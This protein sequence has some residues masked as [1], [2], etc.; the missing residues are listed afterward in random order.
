MTVSKAERLQRSRLGPPVRGAVSRLR[1]PMWKLRGSPA[2]APP[3]RK[4]RVVASYARRVGADTFVETGTYRGDTLAL[5]AP[6]VKQAISIELD[7]TLAD[8]AKRRFAT[9]PNVEIILGDS[10]K[11]LVCVVGSLAS[12]AL[13][14]LDGHY[15]GG[16]TA[17]SGESP[18]M[19]EIETVLSSA[20]EH[21]LL[22]D[23]VRLF[24]GTNGYPSLAALRSRVEALR[25]GW[26]F[27]VVNDIARVGS[28]SSS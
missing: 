4:G 15:S 13:F 24:D 8:F 23:D 2:P 21:T 27:E 7:P 22:I 6:L 16:A 11:V 18:I 26:N 9:R 25:P 12:P 14:W 3:H 28:P 10:A 5:V 17:D 1:I 19:A 20:L